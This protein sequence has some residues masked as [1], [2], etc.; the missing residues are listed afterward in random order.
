[1]PSRCRGFYALLNCSATYFSL[2]ILRAERLVFYRCK[3]YAVGN[4]DGH[5]RNGVLAR[6]VNNSLSYYQE[7]L[8]GEGIDSVFVRSIGKP[9]DE[10]IR[11]LEPFSFREVVPVDP[12]SVLSLAEG[13][14]LDPE[15]A[16]RIAPAV[17]AVAGRG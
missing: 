10:M 14:R 6:E 12:T 7:K 5:G 8:G 15:V 2:L 9:V 17:G 13:L 16:Q 3:S 4:G 11:V 1:M